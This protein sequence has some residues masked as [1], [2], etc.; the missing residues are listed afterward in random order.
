M[1][2][3]VAEW[4]LMEGRWKAAA[5]RFS[6]LTPVITSVDLT[7]TD[8]TS[9][10]L[11]P[12]A[13]A[14]KEWGQPARYERFR[15]LAIRRFESSKNSGVVAQVIKSCLLEPADEKTLKALAPMSAVLEAAMNEELGKSPYVAAWRQFSLAV[16]AYRQDHFDTASY[17]A[18]RSLASPATSSQ[19]TSSNQTLLAMIDLRQGRAEKV[20]ETLKSVRE[21]LTA[22]EAAPFKLGSST[23][24]WFDWGNVRIFL[25]EAEGM[26]ENRQR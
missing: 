10:L 4:N 13:T 21:R 19:L 24:L 3:K 8:E 1:L 18:R 9:R 2:K 14:I 22:W 26:L 5:E 15:E 11:M 12:A 17:W 16:L 6:A 20:P 7:D 25:R 23:D